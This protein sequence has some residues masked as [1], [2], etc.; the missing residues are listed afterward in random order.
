VSDTLHTG[1]VQLA[2][3]VTQATQSGAALGEALHAAAEGAPSRR[4][5]AQLHAFAARVERGEPLEQILTVNS[6]LPPHL[7]GLFRASLATGDPGF[8]IAE[9]VFARKQAKS[10]WRSVAAALAYPLATLFAAYCL[11]VFLSVAV[12]PVFSRMLSEMQLNIPESIRAIFLITEK[13]APLSVL[14]FGAV[15]FAL[16]LVRL[17]GGR[18]GWSQFV[19]T[20]PIIG[21]LW[22]WSGSS[23]LYRALAI[24]L[25]RQIPLPQALELTSDGISDAALA[26]HCRQ[27]AERVVQGSELRRAMQRSPELPPSTFPLIRTGERTGT[28]VVALRTAAEMLESRLQ[29]QS[30]IIVQLAPTAIFLVVLALMCLMVAGFLIPLMLMIQGLT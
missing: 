19:T 7:S 8:T 1:S 24:L 29:A 17:I 20:I 3:E 25:E 18:S 27:L 11:Y 5:A 9:W 4:L 10:H 2:R 30:A 12:L 15:A 23:E 22:H 16:L 26:R 14:V 28:L 13:G 6:P 21:P